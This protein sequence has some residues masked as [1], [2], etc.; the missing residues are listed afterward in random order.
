[1]LGFVRLA[2]YPITGLITNPFFVI[3]TFLNAL[4][5]LSS[6]K[7]YRHF[8]YRTSFNIY[9]YFARALNI[10]WFG[11][12][13]KTPYLGLGDYNLARCFYYTK[14]A[15]FAFWKNSALT[16]FMSLILWWSSFWIWQL[17]GISIIWIGALMILT[18]ISSTFFTNL[19]Q[20][21]YSIMGWAFFPLFLFGVDTQNVVM[22]AG[23]LLFVGFGS[24]SI[25]IL[26]A[27]F[28]P[29]LFVMHGW[30]AIV[31]YIP[32]GVKI[33]IQAFPLL[34]AKNN[35]GIIQNITKAIG[36]SKGNARYVRKNSYKLNMHVAYYMAIYGQFILVYYLLFEVLP[37]FYI[38]GYII[39]LINKLKMRFVDEQNIRL[40]MVTMAIYSGLQYQDWW[41]LASFWIVVNPLPA[42][43]GMD[44]FKGKLDML[45]VLKPIDMSGIEQKC[46]DLLS[47]IKEGEQVMFAWKDPGTVYENV[48]DGY[49]TTYE[50]L[51][52][53]ATQVKVILRPGWWT[54][55][56]L[57]YEGAPDFWA[58]TPEEVIA[59]MKEWKMDY[60]I[61]Y[62]EEDKVL[63]QKWSDAGFA[64]LSELHW[65]FMKEEMKDYDKGDFS[66][67]SWFLL[68]KKI[69]L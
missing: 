57:N 17:E 56:E 11:K 3:L 35:A 22:I 10:Q 65:D 15:L 43:T 49:R 30:I 19:M 36:M 25:A 50:I 13:G 41:L 1:M 32:V 18:C 66:K 23:S 54:V 61:V 14:A 7:V 62:Q 29:L 38:V 28:F 60:A 53:K 6:S 16:V 42:L 5:T 67:L 48:F 40:L 64:Q 31:Y 21:N 34:F 59:K 47:P 24:F 68:K 45:K 26:S 44:I 55:F 8:N 33:F 4:K 2:L 9:F 58:E 20:Q 46:A 39:F 52:Y 37:W 27:F 69:T 63:D 12:S 51:L